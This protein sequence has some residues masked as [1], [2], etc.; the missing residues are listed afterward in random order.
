MG[1]RCSCLETFLV[2]KETAPHLL[3]DRYGSQQAFFISGISLLWRKILETQEPE[4]IFL[5]SCVEKCLLQRT[6]RT[7]AAQV[8]L[9][10]AVQP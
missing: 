10:C 2:K 3:V 1:W 9:L 8:M 6:R 7:L 4:N 5:R